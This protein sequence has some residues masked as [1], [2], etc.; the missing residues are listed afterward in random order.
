MASARGVA[1]NR[2]RD[3]AG[4]LWDRFWAQVDMSAGLLGCWEWTGAKS[5]KRGGTVRGHLLVGSRWKADEPRRYLLAHRVAL[6]LAGEGVS[7]YGRPEHAAHRCNNR[8]C[9]NTYSHLYWA[10]AAE[11]RE[12]RMRHAREIFVPRIIRT[13][14]LGAAPWR[15]RLVE[16]LERVGMEG[17]GL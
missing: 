17:V 10:T 1:A 4:P 13:N 16:E 7:E 2:K 15:V 6:C 3:E 9:C 11:N 12:D 14:T 8:L 5:K